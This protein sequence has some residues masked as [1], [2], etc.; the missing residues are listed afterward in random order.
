VFTE[1]IAKLWGWA[2]AKRR[3]PELLVLLSSHLESVCRPAP[4][5]IE[6]LGA[7][8]IPE[9]DIV[10]I[11]RPVRVQCLVTASQQYHN[12]AV[13]YVS[14]RL[15]ETWAR[16]R[17]GLR[18]G[19][20][21]R[22]DRIFVARPD[23]QRSCLNGRQLEA[24]FATHGFAIVRPELLPLAEQAELFATARVIAGYAGS[25][26]FNMIYSEQ[27]GTRIVIASE[28]YPARNEYLISAVKGDDFHYISC[29]SRPPADPLSDLI[30][31]H[32][33]FEFDFDRDGDALK[34]VLASI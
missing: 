3:H 11:D 6:A 8:G 7:Y 21:Q 31:M 29:P 33:D 5:E 16:L 1:D 18:S 20:G 23:V 25:G 4:F 13:V 12:G 17:E 22:L 2:V 24:T 10:C 26:M 9:S 32:H 34:A 14:E 19:K 27:P 30:P 28:G 15:S